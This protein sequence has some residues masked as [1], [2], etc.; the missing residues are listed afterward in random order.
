MANEISF[1]LA[2]NGGAFDTL[3]N[4]SQTVTQGTSAPGAGDVEIRFSDITT[5]TELQAE[6]AIEILE[7]FIKDR[8]K[9]T[10]F[11]L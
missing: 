1:S 4:G 7:R 8:T 2:R 10:A 6:Q 5:W 3:A 11:P 9:T